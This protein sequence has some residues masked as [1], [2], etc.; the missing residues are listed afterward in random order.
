LGT[1]QLRSWVVVLILVIFWP[2]VYLA[3]ADRQDPGPLDR[4]VL[5]LTAPVYNLMSGLNA[6]FSDAYAERRNLATARQDYFD[7]WQEHRRLRLENMTL[8]A[9]LDAVERLEALVGLRKRFEHHEWAAARVIAVGA[10]GV[11]PILTVDAG[12][13]SRV[14]VGDLAVDD[15][16]VVGRVRSVSE[17]ASEILPIT[18]PMSLV[19]FRG[20]ISGAVG[21][22]NGDGSGGLVAVGVD[23]GYPPVVGEPLLSRTLESTLPEGI[24]IGHVRLLETEETPGRLLVWITPIRPPRQVGPMLIAVDPER[25]DDTFRKVKPLPLGQVP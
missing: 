25:P 18:D 13:E 14:K 2:V 6:T 21:M 15:R 20:E 11:A 3:H 9:R 10:G 22:I 24:P 1:T 12:D 17:G 7:L 5:T 23:P 19:G 4:L 8:K 16:G